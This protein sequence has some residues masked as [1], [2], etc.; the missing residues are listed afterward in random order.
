MRESPEVSSWVASRGPLSLP[1]LSRLIG[2]HPQ[3]RRSVL[4]FRAS[5][6][7]SPF[8][9]G[10]GYSC[11]V[12]GFK[13]LMITG[14]EKGRLLDASTVKREDRAADRA[15]PRHLPGKSRLL[16]IRLFHILGQLENLHGQLDLKRLQPVAIHHDGQVFLPEDRQVAGFCAFQKDL[17]RLLARERADER[18]RSDRKAHV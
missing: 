9:G 5:L 11:M 6:L 1:P 8:Y 15:L 10:P 17:C 2:K 14:V 4:P 3:P 13:S 16:P 12:I 18:K 7:P